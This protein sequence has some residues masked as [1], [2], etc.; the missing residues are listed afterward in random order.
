V[1]G[2]VRRDAR[3]RERGSVRKAEVL[4]DM[5]N[6]LSNKETTIRT[7]SMNDRHGSLEQEVDGDAEDN[8]RTYML[9]YDEILLEHA[10]D[11]CAEPAGSGFEC[12]VS[13][14]VVYGKVHGDTV[15]RF[16]M[17]H[18]VADSCDYSRHVRT[19]NHV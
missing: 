2:I 17:L 15:S 7:Q 1:Q 11:G 19:R 12:D 16:P 4:R 18:A 10:I 13:T 14:K 9:W 8:S 3:A 6:R 5:N